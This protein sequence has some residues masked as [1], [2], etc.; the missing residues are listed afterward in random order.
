[1]FD[2]FIPP[3]Q[4]AVR[5]PLTVP[6]EKLEGIA[7]RMKV[8]RMEGGVYDNGVIRDDSQED[9]SQGEKRVY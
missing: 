3:Q 6:G 9:S 1:M 2:V 8:G 5:H 7:E 4:K